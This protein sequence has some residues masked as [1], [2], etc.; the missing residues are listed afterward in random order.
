MKLR[1]RISPRAGRQIRAAAEWWA[2]HRTA[3]ATR[4]SDELEAAYALLNDL[5]FAGERVS[6][7]RI[8]GLRRVLLGDTQYYLYYVVSEDRAIVKVLSLWHTSRG[9]PPR[10]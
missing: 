3:A 8:D 2:E 4:L 9:K 1:L 10:L 7:S 5:P 6:H